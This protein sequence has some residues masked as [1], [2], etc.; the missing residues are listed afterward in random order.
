MT[1]EALDVILTTGVT[2]ME[3]DY[4]YWKDDGWYVG[5]LDEYPEYTTQGETF[6]EFEDMLRSLYEDILGLSLTN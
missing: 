3:L 6:E 5:H 4:T 1:T 2:V